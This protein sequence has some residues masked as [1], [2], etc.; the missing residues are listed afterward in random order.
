MNFLHYL[1]AKGETVFDY[2][3]NGRLLI[4]TP[5]WLLSLFFGTSAV[6]KVCNPFLF[7]LIAFCW[8]G[9]LFGISFIIL[10]KKKVKLKT[11]VRKYKS[12][13]N[14]WAYLYLF[15]PLIL[16]WIFT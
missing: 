6:L 11:W 12:T 8:W 16:L 5:V 10:P 4:I 14:F 15:L 7:A 9:I 1:Y 13:T 3:L 2:R